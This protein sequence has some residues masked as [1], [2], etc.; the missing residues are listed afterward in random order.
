MSCVAKLVCRVETPERAIRL[1]CP[2]CRVNLTSLE[3][4]SCGL[5][6]SITSG[7]VHALLPERAAH[8]AR[9]IHDYEHIR[10]AEGRS[11]ESDDYYLALP[12]QD[13]TGRNSRQWGIRAH[14]WQCLFRDV[15]GKAPRMD[16]RRI[17]DIGAG[18]CWMSYRLALAGYTPCAVDLLTNN[19]DGL[20]AGARYEPYLQTAMQRFQAEMTRLPF[21]DGQ[22]DAVIFN[23]SFH[24]AE[25][26]EAALGEALRCARIGGLVIVSDT[27]WYASERSGQRM[28]AEKQAVFLRRFGTASDS[29]QSFEYLTDERLRSLANKFT[30]QW[31]VITP[32]YGL[33]WAIRPVVAKLLNR[34][35]P[36]R[37]RIYIARKHS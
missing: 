11:S 25:D 23:A 32:W 28:V 21:Q 35:E 14:T 26:A 3:C 27:P 7:I 12:W 34:R 20:S 37:F 31:R 4:Q 15:L 1:Q 33:R 30:I 16:F 19:S 9:F 2:R 24:Y 10:A 29:I 36:S 18:N 17:L 8:Y 5:M 6:L 22:F 13:C